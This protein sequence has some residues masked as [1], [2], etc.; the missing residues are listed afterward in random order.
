MRDRALQFLNDPRLTEVVA[1]YVEKD[2]MED[3]EMLIARRYLMCSLMFKNA[4]R[5]GA[6]V[7]PKPGEPSA[8]KPKQEMTC[9]STLL[10]TTS[11]GLGCPTL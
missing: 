1:K 4:Q 9:T 6:V 2:Q 10:Y 7:N 11:L 5:Q 8:T 3:E